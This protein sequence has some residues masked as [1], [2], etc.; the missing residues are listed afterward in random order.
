[1]TD[2]AWVNSIVS[3][4]YSIIFSKPPPVRP[5]PAHDPYTTLVEKEEINK[6]IIS[7]LRKKVIEECSGMGFYSRL[8]T[9]PKKT[10]GLHPVL[11]LCPLNQ[12]LKALHFKMETLTHIC[13]M[14]HLK[15]WLTSIDLSDTFLH[16][17]VHPTSHHYL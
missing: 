15:D 5:P 2:S 17:A 3:Q 14:L 9:I 1:M 16:V 8:F 4:G 13:Q 10:G 7:L 6:E 12:Y 11:N